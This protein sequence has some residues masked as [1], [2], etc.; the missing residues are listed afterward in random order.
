[1][2]RREFIASATSMTLPLT[3]NGFNIGTLGH[4]SSIVRSLLSS[5]AVSE[6]RVLVII[7]LNGGNDGLNTVIP[8]E[9]YS[10]YYGLRANIA[11]PE[12]KALKLSG[13]PGTGFHPA[14]TGMRDLYDQGRLA[15]IHSVSYPNPNLSHFRSTDILMTGVSSDQYAET[16]WAG[17]YLNNRY[18]GYPTNYPNAGMQD[19]LAIQIGYISPTALLGPQQPMN[20]TIKDPESFYAL[21]G[22]ADSIPASDLPCCEA[23]RR[24]Q[25][26]RQQQTMAVGY[27]AEVKKA[28]DLGKNLATYPAAT[29]GNNLA[30]QLKI[31]ARLIH[32]G[33]QSKIYFAELR[34]FD[35]HALQVTNSNTSEGEHALL[36]RQ[37]SEAVTAFQN[38]LKLQGT[39]D[40]VIGLTFSDFGRRANSN[41]S[42]GTDHGIAAPMFVFGKSIKRQVVGTIPNLVTDLEPLLPS[43]WDRNQDIKMQ[44]DFRRVY[45]DLLVDW[46]GATEATSNSIL[47]KNFATT[48]LFSDKVQSLASGMW[49]DRAI[50]STG[51]MPRPN[52][53]VVINSG[54][55][56]S[57]GQDI[58]V[59]QIQVEGGGELSLMGNYKVT[60]S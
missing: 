8:L 20:I 3:L 12:S 22:Q 42:F 25:F 7:Y 35:T 14:M 15:V 1:M 24:I 48:S 29:A 54:H 17:R 28:A 49:P 23:G 52:D 6:D 30:E 44:I 27:S 18:P 33:L 55:T 46:L 50:W 4:E 57:V 5:A 56:I 47:Y 34:G 37:L 19:P 16:G 53:I 43:Q 59:K 45:R 13:T 51:R 32:G 2:N 58:T 10:Q 39:E 26:I 9:F 11:I 41:A 60:T 21:V 36:L 38:D 40:R 31:I